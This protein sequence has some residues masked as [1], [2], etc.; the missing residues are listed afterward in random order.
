[1]TLATL[2]EYPRTH[3]EFE[4]RFHTEDDCRAYLERLRWPHGFMCPQCGAGD[5]WK[6]E[7]GLLKCRTCAHQT[8][9][10][11]G[12]SLEGTH[13]PLHLWF[14]AA[15]WMT[16]QKTGVSA[17]SLQHALGL[18]SYRSA[19][20]MLHKLR[21]AMVRPQ[22]SKLHDRVEVGVR[23]F[24]KKGWMCTDGDRLIAIAVEEDGRG[25]GRV[26]MRKVGGETAQEM[27]A[28]IREFVEE[29][30]T[31]HTMEKSCYAG[32]KQLGY[33]HEASAVQD[34]K[35]PEALRRFPRVHLIATLV[36][37]WLNGTYQGRYDAVH[38]DRYLEEFSFRFN[39]RRAPH[40]GKIFYRL[41][42]SV[43]GGYVSSS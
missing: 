43:V 24:C 42:Q 18:G 23:C 37:R 16:T 31:V 36:K 19:W 10:I 28:F 29:G 26:R 20:L 35:A 34:V 22:R 3:L 41:M 12:T 17:K 7:R 2:L 13:I 38:L 32:L 30:S 8:S 5:Y 6:T 14:R 33:K 1:M 21:E 11:A 27:T 9:L 39:R 40:P 4:K 25:V 15:W